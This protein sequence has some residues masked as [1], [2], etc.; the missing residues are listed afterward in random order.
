MVK[1][2]SVGIF[3]S[4]FSYQPTIFWLLERLDY[5]IGAVLIVFFWFFGFW[6]WY[7]YIFG[8]LKSVTYDALVATCE[9]DKKIE[10]QI[11]RFCKPWDTSHLSE[12]PMVSLQRSHLREATR[13]MNV[14]RT[15]ALRTYLSD[16]PS[17]SKRDPR[18]CFKIW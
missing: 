15:G 12:K 11:V 16:Q 3:C 8:C 14:S 13:P 5:R 2:V 17:S 6:A 10:N 9:V 4:N 1:G 7:Q 18:P